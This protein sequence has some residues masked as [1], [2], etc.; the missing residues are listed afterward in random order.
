MKKQICLC[1]HCGT[2]FNPINGF[3]DMEIN[4]F[5]FERNID[6][7]TDCHNELYEIIREF[8]NLDGKEQP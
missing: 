1:D 7:C 8:A 3:D 2:E 6:L 4:Y 5:G